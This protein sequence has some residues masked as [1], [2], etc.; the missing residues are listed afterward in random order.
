MKVSPSRAVSKTFSSLL[1]PKLCA[2][3][4][5]LESPELM[6]MVDLVGF[7]NRIESVVQVPL[8]H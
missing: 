7:A 3:G 4:C 1:R 5:Q 8:S 2:S 6:N